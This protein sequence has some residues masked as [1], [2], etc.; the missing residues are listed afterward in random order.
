MEESKKLRTRRDFLRQVGVGSLVAVPVLW[1]GASPL[2]AQSSEKPSRRLHQHPTIAI[3]AGHGGKDPG[4]IG[5]LGTLEKLVTIAV[6]RDLALRLQGSGRFKVVLTRWDDEFVELRHRVKIARAG[7]ADLLISLHADATH[8]T[9]RQGF[10]VYTLGETASDPLA[11]QLAVRENAMEFLDETHPKNSPREL[12]RIL[13][14]RMRQETHTLS[15]E[16]AS[17]AVSSLPPH[18]KPIERPHRQANFVVLRAP[19]IPSVLIEM[20]FLSNYR[21]EKQL[22]LPSYQRQLGERMTLAVHHY[23]DRKVRQG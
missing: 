8:D 9:S 3:D 18:I 4:A 16:M 2:L 20:G 19:D 14:D 22:R 10:S 17:V 21:S 15:N 6:A 13:F 1:G 5:K 11:E 23:F 12:R 7:G